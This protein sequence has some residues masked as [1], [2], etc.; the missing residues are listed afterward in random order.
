VGYTR[1]KDASAR[2]VTVSSARLKF[3]HVTARHR[4][5]SQRHFV[6]DMPLEHRDQTL[7]TWEW[8]MQPGLSIAEHELPYGIAAYQAP[9]RLVNVSRLP[10]MH[11][12]GR[13]PQLL[14]RYQERLPQLL[15]VRGHGRGQN[16][17]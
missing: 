17:R 16:E 3:A 9:G 14:I 7:R 6:A 5:A 15:P 13:R 11:G 2:L 12:G 4:V 10:S 1:E 8:R